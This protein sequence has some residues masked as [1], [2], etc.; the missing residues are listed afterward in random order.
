MTAWE[1][2]DQLD[3]SI[4]KV[5]HADGAMP[6]LDWFFLL[7][8]RSTTWIPLYAFML[9]WAIRNVRQY[10]VKFALVTLACSGLCDYISSSILKPFFGRLRPCHDEM[11]A[12][13]MRGIINCAGI[14]SMPSGHATNHFG[15]ASIWFFCIYYMTG[16][17][18]YWLWVWAAMICYAQIYVG[19]HYPGDIIAGAFLGTMI[20]YTMFKVFVLWTKKHPPRRLSE[21]Y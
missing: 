20:G 17:K 13:I 7:L 18:W 6:A 21:Q 11:L 8:R 9:Y 4:F 2:L 15:L 5:I 3:R 19:K 12:P 10:V 1:W 14:Y 16:K